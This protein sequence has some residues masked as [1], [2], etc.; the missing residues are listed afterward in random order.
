MEKKEA[1]MQRIKEAEEEKEV[2]NLG[3]Q[4]IMSD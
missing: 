1:E 3:K 4:Q 2:D